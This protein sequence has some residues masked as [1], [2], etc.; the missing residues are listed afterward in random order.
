[1]IAQ[2]LQGIY[3]KDINLKSLE[4]NDSSVSSP[5]FMFFKL[6]FI[7]KTVFGRIRFLMIYLTLQNF[8]REK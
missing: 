1:M 2:T 6:L 3:L 5:S 7:H 8:A 4:K